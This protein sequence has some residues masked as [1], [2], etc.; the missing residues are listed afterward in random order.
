M[1]CAW[2]HHTLLFLFSHG[3]LVLRHTHT[4]THG[5]RMSIVTII[6]RSVVRFL[7]VFHA[8]FVVAESRAPTCTDAPS[9]LLQVNCDTVHVLVATVSMAS[10]SSLGSA[11]AKHK[12]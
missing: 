10:S 5:Q 3:L 2:T 7:S 8:P 11:K 9:L 1:P 6:L 4:H 12:N